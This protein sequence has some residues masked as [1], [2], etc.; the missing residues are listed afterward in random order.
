MNIKMT[1]ESRLLPTSTKVNKSETMPRKGNK[2]DGSFNNPN[3]F[4][5]CFIDIKL[6]Y[7]IYIRN[8]IFVTVT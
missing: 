5:M 1:Y 3:H 6:A 2:T 4:P 7:A 8:T